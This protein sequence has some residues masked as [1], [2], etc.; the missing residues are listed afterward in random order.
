M[1][2][3]FQLAVTTGCNNLLG[4][5][6]PIDNARKNGRHSVVVKLIDGDCVEMAEKAR[7]D[8]IATATWW[9]PSEQH[10]HEWSSETLWTLQTELHRDEWN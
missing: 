2:N 5:D 9:Q 1:S 3:R 10:K 8:G 4:R 7:C 6:V